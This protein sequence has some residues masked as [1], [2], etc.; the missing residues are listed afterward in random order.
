MT[1]G[2]LQR[3]LASYL[4]AYIVVV[5]VVIGA[6]LQVM[7]A[8]LSGAR[9]FDGLRPTAMRIVRT[10]PVVALFALPVLIG[11][12][13]LYPWSDLA[14]LPLEARDAVGRKEAWLN[15]PFFIAR[16]VVY[17]GV[18]CFFARLLERRDERDVAGLRKVSAAGVIVV[19]L[20]LTFAAFDWVMS[21]EPGWYSTIYGIYLFAGGILAA[22]ALIAFVDYRHAPSGAVASSFALPDSQTP[23]SEQR[24]ASLA[25]LI[26]TFAIFW[27]YIAF[28]QYL[29]VWIGN[30]P[31]EVPWYVSRTKTGWAVLAILAGIGQ[32]VVPF[33]ALIGYKMKRRPRVLVVTAVCILAAHVIDTF[34]LVMPSLFPAGFHVDVMDLVALLLLGAAAVLFVRTESSAPPPRRAVPTATGARSPD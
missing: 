28:S 25:K 11:T 31:S 4:F 26:F 21:L 18:W 10:M 16:A 15:V 32:F 14:R 12:S 27:A 30:L 23:S 1:I 17:L 8:H 2:L 34:W 19:G 5:S 6:M 22:L 29:I 9:W 20:T 3:A 33:L 7:I 24:I 13:V